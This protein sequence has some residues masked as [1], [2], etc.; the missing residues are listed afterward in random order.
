MSTCTGC[1]KWVTDG[2]D[3]CEECL[4]EADHL[5]RPAS[6]G[7]DFGDRRLRADGGR[8]PRWDRNVIGVLLP[9]LV[10]VLFVLGAILLA[11]IEPFVGETTSDTLVTA[12]AFLLLL[13]L[14][15]SIGISPYAFHRDKAVVASASNWQPS[16]LYYLLFVPGLNVLLAVVYVYQRRAALAAAGASGDGSPTEAAGQSDPGSASETAPST[17]AGEQVDLPAEFDY[18]G[19]LRYAIPYGIASWLVGATLSVIAI[20][21]S[22]EPVFNPGNPFTDGIFWYITFHGFVRIYSGQRSVWMTS[23]GAI[24]LIFGALAALPLLLFGA[25]AVKR[26]GLVPA[27]ILQGG[28]AG[29]CLALGYVI[30]MAVMSALVELDAAGVVGPELA[31]LADAFVDT[32]IQIDTA[33]AILAGLLYGVIFG[34][35]G[36]LTARMR[37]GT[38]LLVTLLGLLGLFNLL[39]IAVFATGPT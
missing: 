9:V 34:G 3:R 39:I 36:G 18:R 2:S 7:T 23:E 12:L 22:D 16:D 17:A 33:S 10:V 32:A 19:F 29:S 13:L 20:G 25:L 30:P 4:G 24:V 6:A 1:G 26:S 28:I 15:G 14:G 8:V 35:L 5:G 21:L 11:I 27:S 31:P 38:Y 37:G